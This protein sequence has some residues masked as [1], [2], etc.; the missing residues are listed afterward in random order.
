[1]QDRVRAQED[2]LKITTLPLAE[3]IL[4]DR[5]LVTVGIPSNGIPSHEFRDGKPS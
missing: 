1:M 3:V 2:T 4:E 5:K